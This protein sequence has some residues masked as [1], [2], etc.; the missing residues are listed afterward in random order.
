MPLVFLHE[1]A[2][3][4]RSWEVQVRSFA[5]NYRCVV[6]RGPRLPTI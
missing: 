3:D 6:L 2:G 5:R 1:F 4:H